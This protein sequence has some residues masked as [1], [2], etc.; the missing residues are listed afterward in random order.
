MSYEKIVT[1]DLKIKLY[2]LSPN[3]SI[4]LKLSIY[5]SHKFKVFKS[6]SQSS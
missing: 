1:Q 3:V 5:E 6:I 2:F 4:S